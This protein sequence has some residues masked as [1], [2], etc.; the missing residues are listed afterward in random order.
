M[1]F[2]LR[3]LEMKMEIRSALWSPSFCK[4]N[5]DFLNSWI[6]FAP[7]LCATRKIYRRKQVYIDWI[8]NKKNYQL[9][10]EIYAVEPSLKDEL[11]VDDSFIRILR[12]YVQ[13][14]ASHNRLVILKINAKTGSNW[15]PCRLAR[16]YQ[17]KLAHISFDIP[18]DILW[19]N[20][21]QLISCIG[22]TA[23]V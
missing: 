1:Y 2:I 3:F 8:K 19:D 22:P 10:K 4:I 5:L 23:I 11:L 9:E 7:W 14:R 15:H 6:N 13:L 12:C 17:L 18:T 20:T 16:A 21:Y